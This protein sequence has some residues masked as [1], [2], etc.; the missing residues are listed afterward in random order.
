MLSGNSLRNRD[1]IQHT[2]HQFA[3]LFDDYYVQ[4]YAHWDSGEEWIDLPHE[5]TVLTE[6]APD[7][8]H[9]Y[10]V[11]AKSIG[12]VLA[13]QAT[14][15][16][17]IKP[18]FML[19]CGL[20]LGYINEKYET[21]KKDLEAYEG[22]VVI[23]HNQHDTV[24][25]AEAVKAYLGDVVDGSRVAFIDAPGDSHDYEDYLILMSELSMLRESA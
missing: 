25:D 13:L 7:F 17:I 12:T 4:N 1:W 9:P 5:L 10:G 19:F 24:G 8:S 23:I 2:E 22:K 15:K 21:F 6:K 3:G 14:Q 16:D 11:F 18:M 20:P